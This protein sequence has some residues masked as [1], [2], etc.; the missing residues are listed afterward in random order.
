MSADSLDFESSISYYQIAASGCGAVSQWKRMGE[1]LSLLL[2]RCF[3]LKCPQIYEPPA[4]TEE[5]FL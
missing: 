1:R 2:P 4:L 3:L 5:N